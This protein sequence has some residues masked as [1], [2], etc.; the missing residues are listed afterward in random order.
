[1]LVPACLPACLPARLPT[2]AVCRPGYSIDVPFGHLT[3][4]TRLHMSSN[5]V[6]YPGGV[7]VGSRDV[8]PPN[9]VSLCAGSVAGDSLQPLASLKSLRHLTLVQLPAASSSSSKGAAATA[10]SQEQQ[11]KA[12][13]QCLPDVT[14]KVASGPTK[15]S[16]HFNCHCRSTT[17]CRGVV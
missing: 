8:L 16:K 4:L 5:S 2:Y 3:A 12:A 15:A 9:L 1:M 13:Q 7:C 10:Q 6:L 11:L 17:A 14:I